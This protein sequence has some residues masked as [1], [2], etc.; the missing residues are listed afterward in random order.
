MW[1]RKLFKPTKET[2]VCWHDT[3]IV[4]YLEVWSAA[5]TEEEH[6]RFVHERLGIAEEDVDYVNQVLCSAALGTLDN[7]V[8]TED[9][10]WWQAAHRLSHSRRK[11]LLK[12][13]RQ[14]LT[15]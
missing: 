15:D 13:L 6:R 10:P 5:P 7:W 9:D 8:D 12:P 4:E 2:H 14:T 3:A 11:H 1:L